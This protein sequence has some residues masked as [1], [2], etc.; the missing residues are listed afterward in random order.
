MQAAGRLQ[1]H[2]IAV[3]T[4]ILG[5]MAL[6]HTAALTSVI[7]AAPK[8]PLPFKSILSARLQKQVVF[9][10]VL[11]RNSRNYSK[12]SNICTRNL[13]ILSSLKNS[14]RKSIIST[15]SDPGN[16]YS[17]KRLHIAI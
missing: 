8:N 1:N 6:S 5:K 12:L 11:N 10:F 7:L 16:K 15:V 4:D 3:A 9:T 17:P 14:N 13:S 2:N